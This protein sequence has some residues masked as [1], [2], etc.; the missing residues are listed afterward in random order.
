M[1]PRP[2]P[3]LLPILPCLGATLRLTPVC[4][5]THTSYTLL[6]TQS[7]PGLILCARGWTPPWDSLKV[8]GLESGAG[9]KAVLNVTEE[10]YGLKER[11]WGQSPS[12]KVGS[13]GVGRVSGEWNEGGWRARV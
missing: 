11:I 5:P 13:P 2:L 9:I 10:I 1:I 3:Q 7:Q 6:V 12:H 4:T 8:S